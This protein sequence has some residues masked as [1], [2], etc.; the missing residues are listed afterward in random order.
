MRITNFIQSKLMTAEEVA[1][2]LPEKVTIGASGFTPAGYPKV[3]PTAFAKRIEDETKKGKEFS[4]NLYTGA[5]TGDELDGVLARTGAMK[6]RL[7]YQANADLRNQINSGKIEY[8]DLHL[9]HVASYIT[10]GI[11]EPIDVAIVEAVDVT[12]DG[13]IYLTTS[14]GMS[15]TYINHAKEIFIELNENHPLELKGFHDIYL[16]DLPPKGRPIFITHVDDRIG[17]PYVKCDPR[18][19]KGIVRTNLL[20]SNQDFKKPDEISYRIAEH[21]LEFILHEISKGRIPAEY[22]PFQSGVGNVAN[23][24]LSCIAKDSRFH[25]IEM[26]TEVIQDSIFDILDADKL[27]CASTCALT[28]SKAGQDRFHANINELRPKFIIRPQEISNHPE[29]I[30]RMGIISMNTALEVDIYG[31][32]N[33]TH[34][35]GTGMMNGIG[36]S[37][38][39]TRNAYISIFMAPSVAKN[40]NISAFVPMVSHVDHHEHSTQ[41]IVSEYGLADVRGLTPKERA[42]VIIENCVHPIYRTPLKEYFNHALEVSKTKHTPHDLRRVFDWHIKYLEKGTMKPD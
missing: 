11:L 40:G 41:V 18:K 8:T 20:D 19:I 1:V 7:P 13:R 30:R 15:A 24:V 26:Y 9:S 14:S 16:P 22:L 21:I 17:A 5:S 29:V 28:F 12:A 10:H 35:M 23:A 37:G 38:D 36:G 27:H 4:I 32:V 42:K 33:S 2:V 6:K 31:N 3:I 39:F 34:V 25:A